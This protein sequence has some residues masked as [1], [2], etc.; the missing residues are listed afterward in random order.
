MNVPVIRELID[1]IKEKF[2][3]NV[4]LELYND[5][6]G[7]IIEYCQGANI[8]NKQL[9]EFDGLGELSEILQPEITPRQNPSGLN[10]AG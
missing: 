9:A 6:S 4:Y 2:G 5:G 1:R 3:E 10:R 7:A 8:T